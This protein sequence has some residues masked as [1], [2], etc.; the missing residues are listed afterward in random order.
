MFSHSQSSLSFLSPR[1]RFPPSCVTFLPFRHHWFFCTALIL[2]HPHRAQVL[3]WARCVAAKRGGWRNVL[4]LIARIQA[5]LPGSRPKLAG[6]ELG[7]VVGSMLWAFVSGEWAGEGQGESVVKA[8]CLSPGEELCV[9]MELAVYSPT[10]ALLKKQPLTLTL[11]LTLAIPPPRAAP[12]PNVVF[13]S[14]VMSGGAL[15]SPRSALPAWPSRCTHL[16]R[17]LA[18]NF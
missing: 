10:V 3:A 2:N 4:S 9:V 17:C 5:R 7:L 14:G 16:F 6:Q 13:E 12:R 15:L 18:M 11:T 8:G 1:P